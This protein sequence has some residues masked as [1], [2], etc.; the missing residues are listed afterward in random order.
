MNGRLSVDVLGLVS[1]S[2]EGPLAILVLAAITLAL[3]R[4]LWRRR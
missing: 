3:T 2:A 1:G 4:G